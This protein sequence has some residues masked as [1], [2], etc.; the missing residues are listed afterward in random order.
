MVT[1]IWLKRGTTRPRRQFAAARTLRDIDL[2]FARASRAAATESIQ[3]AL[4]RVVANDNSP[5]PLAQMLLQQEERR[6]SN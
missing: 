5:Q 1:A 2:W 4:K 3:A 6:R